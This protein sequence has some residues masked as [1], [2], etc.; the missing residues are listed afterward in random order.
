LISRL[1][2]RLGDFW[3]YSILLFAAFRLGDLI[4]AVVGLWL[5]PKYVSPDELGAVMPLMQFSAF[6]GFPM[7]VLVTVFSRYLAKFKAEGDEGRVKSA[8]HWFIGSAIV[9]N[10]TVCT[11]SLLIMPHFFERIRV[12]EGSLGFLIIVSGLIGPLGLVFS[13]ALQGLKKFKTI[14]FINLFSSPIRL[15]VMLVTMPIRALSGYM[16]GQIAGPAFC[17]V[18]AW[19]SLRRNVSKTVKAVPFWQGQHNEVLRYFALVFL[20]LGIGSVGAFIMPTIIRQRLPEV[21]S[22]AYYMIT[23]FAELATFASTTLAFV[24]FPLASEAHAKGK[25]PLKLFL[26]TTAGSLGFG[27]LISLALYLFGSFIFNLI[28]TCRPY[29][30]FV[31]DMALLAFSMALSYTCGNFTDYEFA[32][33]RFRFFWWHIPLS[34]FQTA[35]FVCFAGYTFFQGILPD[36]V[37]AWMGAL[38]IATLRNFIWGMIVFGLIRT[39]LITLHLTFRKLR[40][41]PPQVV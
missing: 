11:L 25:D 2:A 17:I 33:N 27:V 22:A 18:T 3:W 9:F 14:T 32:C 16:V 7:A 4:N 15:G 24:M 34:I 6:V 5:V 31:P 26:H 37:V 21:E 12:T 39:L 38:N 35:F 13:R 40:A 23:R 36:A 20:S 28:P 30:A 1:H 29:V 19:I 10:V 41:T 8:L